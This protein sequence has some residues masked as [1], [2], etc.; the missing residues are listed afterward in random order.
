MKRQAFNLL[1]TLLLIA[2]YS[3]GVAMAAQMQL[4][5][6]AT[7]TAIVSTQTHEMQGSSTAL[8][9]QHKA[10]T[11]TASAPDT[12]QTT[13][14]GCGDCSNCLC[15]SV[16]SSV[17]APS[18]HTIAQPAAV[19]HGLTVLPLTFPESPPGFILRPPIA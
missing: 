3:W 8:C 18:R 9:P 2:H 12:T 4:V 13:H 7:A 5:G 19:L 14:H 10:Q 17:I 11:Q 15:I 1:M 16:L 6:M